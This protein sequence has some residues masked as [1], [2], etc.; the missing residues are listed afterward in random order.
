MRNPDLTVHLPVQEN[1]LHLASCIHPDL[2]NQQVYLPVLLRSRNK[3]CCDPPA[4]DSRD[5]GS[6]QMSYLPEPHP[7][8]T[9]FHRNGM[10]FVHISQY[11][12]SSSCGSFPAFRPCFSF[13]PWLSIYLRITSIGAPP[14]VS[15]QKL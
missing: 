12:F 8:L 2:C 3:V 15:R 5:S 10:P 14:V 9:V 7:V 11:S 6:I 4:F 1:P 13:I